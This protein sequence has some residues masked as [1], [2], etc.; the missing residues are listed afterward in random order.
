M[1]YT[2]CITFVC[3]W[4]WLHGMINS[5]LLWR[6]A[7]QSYTQG[8]VAVPSCKTIRLLY[9]A[10]GWRFTLQPVLWDGALLPPARFAPIRYTRP[11]V[12]KYAVD[13]D[14]ANAAKILGTSCYA[15]APDACA[16]ISPGGVLGDN[17]QG[18]CRRWTQDSRRLQERWRYSDPKTIHF[19]FW[20]LFKGSFV[21]AFWVT[22][23]GLGDNR[24]GVCWRWT[25][26][27][28]RLQERWRYRDPKTIHLFL[29]FEICPMFVQ[30]VVCDVFRVL[31][32]I[33]FRI[34][35]RRAV[36]EAHVLP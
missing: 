10:A 31:E 3:L 17:T 7:R 9:L 1:I 32:W 23:C 22:W 20:S 29:Y 33:L 26:D 30:W 25:Q 36:V 6:S 18:V 21:M 35:C 19:L 28:R 12:Y 24:Q 8:A 2:T 16:L 14:L 5:C 34:A 15:W 11:W 13:I 4:A 27:S